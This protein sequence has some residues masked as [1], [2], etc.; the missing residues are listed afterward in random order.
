MTAWSISC[1]CD[2]NP[3]Y[4]IID[5]IMGLRVKFVGSGEFEMDNYG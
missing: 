4:N 2:L 5:G 3:K 1:L